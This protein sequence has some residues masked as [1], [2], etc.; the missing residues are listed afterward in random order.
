MNFI[1][2][3]RLVEDPELKELENGNKVV[4]FTLAVDREYKSKDG[5]KITDFFPFSLWN[6]DAENIANISKKGALIK[7]EGYLKMKKGVNNF[8]E[9]TP[10]IT[11]YT[12]L[13]QQ[14]NLSAKEEKE[15]E[16]NLEK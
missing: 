15:E 10:V 12:H 3:G 6:K 16:K 7:L 11:K 8:D 14:K 4:N 5:K 9:L 13:V 1:T 2:I